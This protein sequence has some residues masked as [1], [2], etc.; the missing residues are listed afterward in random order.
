MLNE[1]KEKKYIELKLVI[2][3]V[4]KLKEQILEE[5]EK[6]CLLL[7]RGHEQLMAGSSAGTIEDTKKT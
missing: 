1:L 5:Q 2:I 6:N 3:K 4:L 7:T